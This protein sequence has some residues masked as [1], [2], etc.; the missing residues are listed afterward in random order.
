MSIVKKDHYKSSEIEEK[1]QKK[2]QE[3]GLYEPDLDA[4]KKPFFNLMM[5][6]YPSAEGLHVGNMYAFTGSDVYGRYKR[7]SGFDV[8][9][10]IGLDGFGIHSENY[11]L[12]VNSHPMDQAKKSQ[13]N[14]YRQLT[15]IGNGFSWKAKLE[16]YDIDYYRWT[17][18]VFVQLFKAGLAY[19]AEAEVNWCPSCKTVLADEQVIE[20]KC[21]RCGSE[22]EKKMLS[23]WFF[24]I[25]S[26]ADKL[27]S[28]LDTIDWTEKIK[29]AQRNW[30]GRSEGAR[31]KFKIESGKVKDADVEVFTTRPD[32]LHGATFMVISPEH[33]LVADLSESNDEVTSYIEEAKGKSAADRRESKEKTGVFSGAYALN[34]I[35]NKQI[36]I[37]IADYVL[38]GYG[39]GAIMAVP[40][41]DQRDYDFAKKYDLPI[42]EVIEGGDISTQ[43]YAG[44]GKLINSGDWD[45]WQIP[46]D[47]SKAIKDIQERG[48][49]EKETTYH[50]RDWLISRQ[51]YWGPPIPMIFCQSCADKGQSWFDTEEAKEETASSVEYVVPSDSEDGLLDTQH[52]VPH[53]DVTGWF[54]EENLP[55]ELPYI[56]DYKPLGTGNSP[57][58]NHP[59][60]YEAA[61][62]HCG[63]KAR[64]E[65]DVS[66]TFL[67]S[68]WYFFRYTSTDEKDHAWNA[69]RV[70]AWLPAA[71]YTG[72][73]EHAVLHLLYTRF[74]SLVF[75]DLGLIS[76]FAEPFPKFFAHGLIIKDGAKM[77][78]SKG[79]VVV[80]DEYI[81]KYGADTLRSYLMFL[82]PY[83]EGGDFRD[84]GIEGMHRF[85]KRVW[86]MGTG[87]NITSTALSSSANSAL[88]KAIKGVTEDL[89]KF[90]YNT[91][92]AKIMTLYNAFSQE[93]E[94]SVEA[95]KTF[96]QLLAPFAP[97]MTEELWEMHG[98]GYSVHNSGW[99]TFDEAALVEDTI[100]IVIQVNGKVRDNVVIARDEVEGK[101][102]I[103]KLARESEAVQRHLNGKEEKTVI[104]VPGKILN[105][106]V[107]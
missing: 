66:D 84:T 87:K 82:G 94:I 44:S 103:E 13:Q 69:D 20:G 4:P 71:Q 93:K 104:Y 51:R 45:G 14:F 83:S 43:A 48:F 23:Q 90:R 36:P 62:P 68:S 24:R 99:P 42:V 89:E 98:G 75:K 18:W 91:A 17:Q 76:H 73:A 33:P 40:A 46:Q 26:Y 81:R 105:F 16:T 39:T 97:H 88:Q 12:K 7:M 52:I 21:E 55:V 101:E 31:V 78:K 47:I 100:T 58:G 74:V 1:W 79:N 59:E 29:I 19:K 72:G 70:K 95:F 30:I 3:S 64:R 28:G 65:T 53:S 35:N 61:C 106:V 49:G 6:P 34:P 54:P 8:L 27:L 92:I 25:T 32:T 22:V 77:S 80:P 102:V 60:F 85:L 96:L 15:E 50:L 56:E 38:M 67:D 10:P 57:L 63:G 5:F 11:A 9:Q 37:W 2:W 86:V 107:T 41:H